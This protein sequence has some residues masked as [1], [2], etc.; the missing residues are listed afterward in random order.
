M[1]RKSSLVYSTSVS[2]KGIDVP[3]TGVEYAELEDRL[4]WLDLQGT[5]SEIE[6]ETYRYLN[7]I[8]RNVDPPT[9]P[10]P[11]KSSPIKLVPSEPKTRLGN[12]LNPAREDAYFGEPRR[13]V[14]NN[15]NTGNNSPPGRMM[16]KGQWLT[17]KE[18]EQLVQKEQARGCGPMFLAAVGIIFL[19]GAILSHTGNNRTEKYV[20]PD[21]IVKPNQEVNPPYTLSDKPGK[22]F[23][24]GETTKES[25]AATTPE[26]KPKTSQSVPN[27]RKTGD[28]TPTAN[29]EIDRIMRNPGVLDKANKVLTTKERRERLVEN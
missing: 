18:I 11:I 5:D 19:I 14:L 10:D 27:Q 7:E 17:P 9:T 1:R 6:W 25:K 29:D 2:Y 12:I 21:P 4:K 16:F 8:G 20:A 15:R 24:P 13:K 23:T 26:V 3:L 22:V 28:N